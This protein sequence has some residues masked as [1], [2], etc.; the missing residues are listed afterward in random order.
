L[1][2]NDACHQQSEGKGQQA[3]HRGQQSWA[4][5]CSDEQRVLQVELAASDEPLLVE[6]SY[7]PAGLAPGKMRL[8]NARGQAFMQQSQHQQSDPLQHQQ[9]ALQ[10]SQ[11]LNQQQKHRQQ[12]WSGQPKAH[13]SLALRNLNV[14]SP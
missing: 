2:A 11:H 5:A 10:Q 8:G 12:R 1:P 6:G 13:K 14:R 9:L 4:Q 3:R 7:P